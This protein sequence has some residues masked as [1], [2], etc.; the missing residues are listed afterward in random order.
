MRA[1]RFGSYSM[2]ATT[3]AIP[4]LSRLKSISRYAFLWPPPRNR[5]EIRPVL[6]RPPVPCLPFTRLFSGFCLVM[7]WRDTTVWKRRV[8]VVGLY[9]LT[10]I[11]LDLRVLRRLLAGLQFHVGFLPVGAISGE[12]PAPP[13]L[14]RG[15]GGP[16]FGHLHLEESLDCLPDL[17]LIG[18]HVDFETQRALGIL[19]GHAFFRHDGPLDHIHQRIHCRPSESFFAAASVSST[20]WW[21]SRSY[22]F[23]SRLATSLT[24]SRFRLDSS[25]LRFS[26]LSTRRTVRAMSRASSVLRISLVLA[27]PSANS[28]TTRS[29]PSRS[30]ADKALRSA[31]NCIFLGSL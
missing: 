20:C 29:S 26:V 12:P 13:Q 10:G 18:V 8:G 14:A 9:V 24:P 16:H 28:L 5:E 2:D 19:L 17:G 23:T 15:G 1:L 4:C 6:L 22:T 11:L 7:S 21:P 27:S 3:A 25:R 30:L 31:P